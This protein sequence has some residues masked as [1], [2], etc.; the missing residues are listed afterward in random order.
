MLTL[1]RHAQT[2][3]NAAHLL[4]GSSDS[5]LTALGRR[6]AEALPANPHFTQQQPTALFV[7]PLGRTRATAAPLAAS[8]KLTPELRP[9]L[10]ERDFGAREGT[11][12]GVHQRGFEKGTGRGESEEAWRRRVRDEGREL[13][14]R[15]GLL[16][17]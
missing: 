16:G 9:G 17:E 14:R 2:E 10:Q 1:I 7:S 8:L 4:Q 5:P 3:A 12:R 11:R 15:A 13:L 6:Q